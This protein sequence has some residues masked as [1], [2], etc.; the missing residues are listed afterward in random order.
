MTAVTFGEALFRFSSPK[1]ERLDSTN[2]LDFWLGGTE[3]NV[4]ANLGAL[5][6]KTKW[7]S[8][9]GDGAV[10]EMVRGRLQRLP[11][12]TSLA[13]TTPGVRMGWYLMES[14]A[15]P[16]PD[17]VFE[18]RA[19]S[20]ADMTEFPFDWKA[21]LKDA[22]IFHTSG[23]TAG[24]SPATTIEVERA[25]KVAHGQGTTVS[26]DFNYRRT[27]WNLEEAVRRQKPL[28]KHV[29]ILYCGHNELDLFFGIKQGQSLAPIFEQYP[30]KTIVMGWRSEEEDHYGVDIFST[31]CKVSSR[32]H[33]VQN[34]DRIGVGD[35]MTA[36]FL[37]ANLEKQDMQHSSEIAAA[38]GALK[39]TIKG[40]MALLKRREIDDLIKGYKAVVR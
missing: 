27:L 20:M 25:M 23:V 37:A 6:H 33:A 15:A 35:S 11:V 7:V 19:G 8:C 17:L 31:D 10:G 29:D 1:G 28:L 36:A 21:I 18:R 38:A 32:R 16:R 14:G 30:I 22:A 5:G 3:L 13:V 9:L 39:Y 26:Y 34:I 2:H 4:A 12:D 40:D 24:L